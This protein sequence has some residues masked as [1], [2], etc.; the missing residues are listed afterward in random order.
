ML[1][2]IQDMCGPVSSGFRPPRKWNSKNGLL[3]L[4]TT[5]TRESNRLK[6]RSI[7]ASCSRNLI[8]NS[9]VPVQVQD[10]SK[11]W[12][13]VRFGFSCTKIQR[14]G[15]IETKFLRFRFGSGSLNP[16][17]KGSGSVQVQD[18]KIV[19]KASYR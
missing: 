8:F 9:A 19:H 6:Y 16:N 10:F 13:Q 5:K 7:Y 17:F 1:E 18:Y 2:S 12:V 15:F 3:Y 14:F 4:N 11:I